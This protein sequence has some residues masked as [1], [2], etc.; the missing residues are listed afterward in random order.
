MQT[1][2]T[3][4]FGR[5]AR[6]DEEPFWG[7]IVIDADTGLIIE[8]KRGAVFIA[9]HHFGEDCL[10]FAGFGDVHIHAREDE[11][12]EQCYKETYT[13]ACDA[14]LHGGVVHV[15][16]M[17]NT[18]KP[19]VGL[20]EF[21][22]HRKRV[23]A[24]NHRVIVINYIGI[25]KGSR[26]L[27]KRGDHCYKCFFGKSV[28][29]LS[30][31]T[32]E[33]L[34]ETIQHYGGEYV[35]FHVE[36]EE[37]VLASAHGK[38]H[39]DRRPA[40]C[41]MEGLRLLLPLI[42]KYGINAKLCHWPMDE[43]SFALI[44]DYRNRGCHI[45]LE[46]SPLHVY[47][48]TADTDDNPALWRELQMNPALRGPANPPR[49]IYGLRI[50]IVDYLATDHAPHT[51]EEKHLAFAKF[52]EKYPNKSNVEIAELVRAEN[53]ELFLA[54]CC[55]NNTSG[56]PWLDTYSLVCLWLMHE[57]GFRPQD[58]ARVAAYNPGRFVNRFLPAQ[59]PGRDF[60]KG[61]GDVAPGYMGSLT[62]LN[63]TKQTTVDRKDLKTKVGWSPFE[64]KTFPGA[65]EAVFTAGTRCD[66]DSA[67]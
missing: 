37:I 58:I 61:F 51:K 10:V 27:G 13:T 53:P 19:L 62:V 12:G 55:E 43:G 23:R 66:S 6:H 63:L 14:A 4:I 30:I 7:L 18:P 3:S 16:A 45:E 41:V 47:F 15:S 31:L 8:V 36:L 42:E 1:G 29:P 2:Q 52:R 33:D 20:D 39:S 32:V 46:A 35:S 9:D 24:I 48:S 5:I 57:H 25:Q 56:A 11:T 67:H 49:I 40:S 26:P 44:Q 65:V 28:G 21:M 64:G 38:T 59:Y 34:E 17:P 60:G 50:A 22:W 54:T